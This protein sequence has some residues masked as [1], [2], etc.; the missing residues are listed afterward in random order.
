MLNGSRR[1][2]TAEQDYVPRVSGDSIK[3][4]IKLMVL[5]D[6]AIQA[7]EIMDHL[8]KRNVAPSKFTVEGIRADLK[9]TLRIL[10]EKGL[11]SNRAL[12]GKL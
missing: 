11:I 7:K 2:D 1:E 9:H 4:Q 5:N 3:T 10:K 8:A 12:A 6:P